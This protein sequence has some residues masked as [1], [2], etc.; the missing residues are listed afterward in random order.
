M[1]W[2]ERFVAGVGVR[3]VGFRVYVGGFFR[4]TAYRDLFGLGNPTSVAQRFV[5]WP[6]GPLHL[7]GFG[8]KVHRGLWGLR[9]WKFRLM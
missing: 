2:F 8:V 3:V 6:G 1:A 4:S 7:P 5:V 9:V